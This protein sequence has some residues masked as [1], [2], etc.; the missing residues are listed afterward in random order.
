MSAALG[1]TADISLITGLPGSGKTLRA[2]GFIKRAIEAGEVVFVCNLNGLKLPHIPFEDPRKWEEIPAG[3]VLVVD[4]AQQ[5]FRT[6]RGGDPPPYLT[7]METIRHK[8]VRLVLMTQQ[9]DY[10]DTHL[11][12]LV[13]LHEH[14]LRENGKE[15]SKIWRHNELMDNVRSEKARSRY[16]SE[17]WQFPKEDYDAYE[18]AEIHTRKRVV[19]SRVKRGIMIAA[20]ALVVV[21][22]VLSR[23]YGFFDNAAKAAEMESPPS[24]VVAREG[25]ERPEGGVP[26]PGAASGREAHKPDAVAD[27]IANLQPRIPELPWSAPIYDGREAVAQPRVFCMDAGA[28]ETASGTHAPR[29]LRCVTEQGSRHVMPEWQAERLAREGEPYNPFKAPQQAQNIA[30]DTGSEPVVAS[31]PALS[32]GIGEKA[33]MPRYGQFRDEPLGPERYEARSW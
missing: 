32:V 11:R 13:G 25:G 4:E 24:V 3:S 12:G 26:S 7:A 17:I 20:A 15:A 23:F 33:Q 18:S 16:D 28:G 22:W 21:G 27:Y 10:L 30:V 8:G 2:V 9:P 31:G 14:L 29:E 5:F 19:S 6:R 1:K